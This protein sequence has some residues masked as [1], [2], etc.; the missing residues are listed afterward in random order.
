MSLVQVVRGLAPIDDMVVNMFIKTDEATSPV[1]VGSFPATFDAK[2][3]F[4]V[5]LLDAATN[6]YIFISHHG[7]IGYLLLGHVQLSSVCGF[8]AINPRWYNLS[9]R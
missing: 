3:G 7:P 1:Y 4:E 9:R 5:R 6:S 2:T 8:D